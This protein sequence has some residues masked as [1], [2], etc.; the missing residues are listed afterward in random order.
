MLPSARGTDPNRERMKFQAPASSGAFVL[1]DPCC[2]APKSR[3]Q[4]TLRVKNCLGRH[5][6][7][8]QLHLKQRTRR[9]KIGAT[10]SGQRLPHAPAANN[11]VVRSP[12]RHLFEGPG[13]VLDRWPATGDR[14]RRPASR[15]TNTAAFSSKRKGSGNRPE[16][17]SL[18]T[19]ETGR[20]AP[21]NLVSCRKR[22]GRRE[23]IPFHA[24]A[25]A[26]E[27]LFRADVAAVVARWTSGEPVKR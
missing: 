11:I 19:V 7:S 24:Q 17:R 13:M 9:R 6:L 20:T 18:A 14:R 15:M 27:I 5:R 1:V 22:R 16:P 2:A 23:R 21:P 10:V 4:M 26:H 3:S 8:R 12:R 25:E